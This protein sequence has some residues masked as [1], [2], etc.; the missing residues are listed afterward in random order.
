MIETDPIASTA[1]GGHWWDVGVPEVSTRAEVR[2]ARS[3][4]EQA[5]GAQILGE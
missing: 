2:A 5:R 3:E 4:Y 1:S